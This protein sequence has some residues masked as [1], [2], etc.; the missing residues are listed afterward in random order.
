MVYRDEKFT[1]LKVQT[2]LSN[3]RETI[4][5]ICPSEPIAIG[6]EVELSRLGAYRDIKILSK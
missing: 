5:D 1:P 6:N 4:I 2:S 3:E